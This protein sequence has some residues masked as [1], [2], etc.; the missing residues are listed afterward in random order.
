MKRLFVISFFVFSGVLLSAC[1]AG[2]EADTVSTPIPTVQA[3]N[4]IVA[5]GRLEPIHYVDIAFNANGTVSEVLVSEGEQVSEG[6]VIARLENSEAK[7]SELANAEEAFLQAQLAFDSAEA[8][9][10]GKLAEANEG[11]RKAQ[12][13]FDN[14][15]I[16]SEIVD[17]GTRDAL[18]YTQG[19]LDEA[20]ANY[21]PYRYSNPNRGTGK[22][23]KKR[24]DDAWADYNRAIRWTT[25]EASLESA[26]AE[27]A[28]AQKEYD[29]LSGGSDSDEKALAEAQFEAARANLAAARAALEDVELHAPFDGTVAGLKVKSGE[30]VTPGQVAV[31]VA[32]FSGWIVKTTDLTELDVVEISEGQDVAITLDAIPGS[33]LNGK[34]KTIGQN[35]TQ[36]Q[37]DVVYEVTVE[38]TDALPNM[39]WGMTAVVKFSE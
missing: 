28:Q 16:P 19:K 26:K 35:Y 6:Q 25:L 36:Q 27:L 33:E 2:A 15:N 24:L 9:A 1:G 29:T 20:R 39:R 17:M 8:A 30:A 3:E 13:E 7:Q 14:F 32:D 23:Y 18:N 34:V 5:E 21:E 12:Y 38:L 10:L 11:A 4:V 31:S 37:G 22:E